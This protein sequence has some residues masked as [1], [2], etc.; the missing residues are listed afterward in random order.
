[1]KIV[2]KKS[3]TIKTYEIEQWL[4]DRH[5]S[6]IIDERIFQVDFVYET[7]KAI[8]ING[9]PFKGDVW[10]PKS[11]M[12]LIAKRRFGVKIKKRLVLL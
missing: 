7:K 3:K 5:V 8:C 9:Y 1:M 4:V 6:E 12:K 2:M 11:K 10:L